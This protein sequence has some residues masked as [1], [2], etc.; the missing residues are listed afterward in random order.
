MIKLDYD[1]ITR[2]GKNLVFMIYGNNFQNI[3]RRRLED[4]RI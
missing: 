2:K 1:M 3:L 4:V